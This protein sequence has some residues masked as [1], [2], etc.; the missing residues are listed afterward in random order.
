MSIG[1]RLNEL[2]D[3]KDWTLD[4]LAEASEVSAPYISKL[5]RDKALPQ[6]ETL[7]AILDAL[8]PEADDVLLDRDRLELERLGYTPEAA[9][10]VVLLEQLDPETQA[11]VIERLATELADL[12]RDTEGAS[13]IRRHGDAD[14]EPASRD[15]VAAR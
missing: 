7:K 15:A 14:R 13:G 3:A 1:K 5:E 11:A 6:R 12:H 4:E 8:G 2:R 9:R 10:L